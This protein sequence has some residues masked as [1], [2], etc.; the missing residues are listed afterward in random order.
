M[1]RNQRIIITS[2]AENQTEIKMINTELVN[3]AV[4]EILNYRNNKAIMEF[5]TKEALEKTASDIR[6]K[7]GSGT[8]AKAVS[9]LMIRNKDVSERVEQYINLG[10]I[11]C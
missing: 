5:V 11:G 7:T 9:L 1:I 2:A 10:L 8:T 6:E 3:T 4:S